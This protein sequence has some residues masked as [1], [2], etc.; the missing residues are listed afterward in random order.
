MQNHR[1]PGFLKSEAKNWCRINLKE[2]VCVTKDIRAQDHL[3]CKSKLWF[4][5]ICRYCD[6]RKVTQDILMDIFGKL[7]FAGVCLNEESPRKIRWAMTKSSHIY[8]Y[9]ALLQQPGIKRVR[10]LIKCSQK[11]N[12]NL[13]VPLPF[14]RGRKEDVVNW[15]SKIRRPRLEHSQRYQPTISTPVEENTACGIPYAYWNILE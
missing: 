4:Y 14:N 13:L 8:H 7:V 10:K 3:R 6:S 1:T 9:G 5:L 2:P 12:A 15:E 11:A